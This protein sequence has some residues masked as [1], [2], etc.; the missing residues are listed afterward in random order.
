[1]F[2]LSDDPSFVD[3]VRDIV[4]LYGR[5]PHIISA[6]PPADVT[7]DQIADL[8]DCD[9]R[10]ERPTSSLILHPSRARGDTR[11]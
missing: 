8:L 9:L 2:K 3:K 11:K 10:L 7:I 1:M 6:F 5:D 4:G